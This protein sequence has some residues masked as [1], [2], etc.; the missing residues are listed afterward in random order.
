[1]FGATFIYCTTLIL[2]VTSFRLVTICSINLQTV[3]YHFYFQRT[4]SAQTILDYVC[5]MKHIQEKDFLGLRYQDHNKHRYWL[6]L[7]RSIG[8]VVK[9]FRSKCFS[10]NIESNSQKF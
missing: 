8:H 10:R 1:M 6:D 9:Q 4:Q 7:S 3:Q 2:L 5:E